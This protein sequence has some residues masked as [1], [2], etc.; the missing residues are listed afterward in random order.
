MPSDVDTGVPMGTTAP[1]DNP[2]RRVKALGGDARFAG[3]SG[4]LAAPPVAV[5]ALDRSL[6]STAEINAVMGATGMTVHTSRQNSGT[7][8]PG[9]PI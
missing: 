9:S 8:V 7:T 5:E 6:L 2:R 3:H 4:A 1:Q